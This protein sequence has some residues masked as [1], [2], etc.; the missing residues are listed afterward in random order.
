MMHPWDGDEYAGDNISDSDEDELNYVK[1]VADVI[2]KITGHKIDV[3]SLVTSDT[4]GDEKD[5]NTN[6][7]D[8]GLKDHCNNEKNTTKSKTTNKKNTKNTKNNESK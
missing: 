3:V 5:D 6:C 4:D 2:E 7:D 8:C 1:H